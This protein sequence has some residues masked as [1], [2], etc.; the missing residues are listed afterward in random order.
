M[1]DKRR[2]LCPHCNQ[3]IS[4]SAYFA[5]K[6]RYFDSQKSEWIV[7]NHP[8]LPEEVQGDE[9]SENRM[10]HPDSDMDTE[11][12]VQNA[13]SDVDDEVVDDA[14]GFGS[15]ETDSHD[16]EQEPEVVTSVVLIVS[17]FL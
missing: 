2:T 5:H 16:S 3:N 15:S 1:D 9:D 12:P 6:A 17:I 8:E 10:E 7:Q 4:Y 14:D 13:D 11:Y